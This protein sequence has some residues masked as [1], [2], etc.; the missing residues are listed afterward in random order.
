MMT[1]MRELFV[2]MGVPDAEVLQEA[3]VSR[4]PVETINGTEAMLTA[5]DDDAERRRI[6]NVIFTR[7]RKTAELVDGQTVLEAA[8][9]AGI[10]D[11]VR[12]PVR[13]LRPVQDASRLGPRDA[14]R[15]RMR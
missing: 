10:D 11:P 1:A 4:P 15:S 6:A 3:F 5:D 14:W 9:D 8:E 2:D 12:V 7:S 13:H